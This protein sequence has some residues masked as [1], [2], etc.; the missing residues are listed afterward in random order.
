[1]Q[2]RSALILFLLI[3]TSFLTAES[4]V[5]RVEHP[6]PDLPGRLIQAGMDIAGYAPGEYLDVIGDQEVLQRLRSWGC[7]VDIH[8]TAAQVR[9]SLTTRS[10]RPIDGYREYDDLVDDLTEI[11]NDH[12]DI[13]RMI[14]IGQSWGP[15]YS[16]DG[17][18]AYDDFQHDIWAMKVSDNPDDDEDE[19]CIYYVG[20]HHAREPISVEVT[21][22]ILEHIT[23]NYGTD[24]DVTY[25][26]DNKQIWFV[27]LVNPD[28][29]KIVL[30]QTD[31]WWRK[32]I[33]DNNNNH[34]FDS[35]Y[36]Y[37]TGDD[38]VDPNRNYGYT[39][40][41]VGS[42]DDPNG[43]TY[44]GPNEFSEPETQAV[45]DLVEAHHF[46][47]GISYHSHG[48]LVLYPY[49]YAEGIYAPDHDALSNLGIAM[50]QQIDGLSG[51]HYTPQSSWA[52]Y[53]TMGGTDDWAYGTRGVFAYT[54][55]LAEEFIP[56][57]Y[58][59]QQICDD[60]LPGAL[61]LLRRIDTAT[62]TGHVTEAGTRTPL[63][64]KIIVEEVDSSGEPRMP[65]RANE[66][67]GRYWRMLEPG[68]YTVRYELY[69][70]NT[71]TETVTITS[72]GVTEIDAEL[73]TVGTT[74]IT[75]TVMDAQ[76]QAPV[77]G[78]TV[79][80]LDA[81]IDP[82]TTGNDGT[83]T[84]SDIYLGIYHIRIA[85]DGYGILEQE[86]DLYASTDFVFFL[87]PPFFVD[88]FESGDGNW[89]TT[90]SWGIITDPDAWSGTHAMT[91]SPQGDYNN[92]TETYLTLLDQH[93]FS[94]TSSVG[95]SF[96]A[97][98]EIETDWDYVYFQYRTGSSGWTTVDS[99]TGFED[100]HIRQYHIA[101]AAG[102]TGVRF[103]FM[104]DSDTYVTEDGFYLDDF[105]IYANSG[106][107][108]QYGDID[109]NGTVTVADAVYG[110]E[111]S[112]GLDPIPDIDPI[113]WEP[114]R[115]ASADVDGNQ[116]VQAFDASLISQYASGLIDHFPVTLTGYEAPEA[117][118]DIALDG[119]ELV[120]TATG[121]L[122]GFN[123]ETWSTE[124]VIFGT[125]EVQNDSMTMAGYPGDVVFKLALMSDEAVSGEFLRIGFGVGAGSNYTLPLNMVV[126]DQAVEVELDVSELDAEGGQTPPVET[127]LY[128]NHPNPFN[129]VTAIR[130]SLKNQS[131]T[132]L[133]I[134]NVRGQ[135]IR[136]LTNDT[137]PAGHHQVVWD[138][139]DDRG[140]GVSSGVYLYRLEADG[141]S[142][143]RRMLL[144]K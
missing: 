95:I 56:P 88:D 41:N 86:I 37:G 4:N 23:D 30:D 14:S 40:G 20:A 61:E 114:L 18:S 8:K 140:N 127:R 123:L 112:C 29:H 109:D 19:P 54:V 143:S 72:N 53:P 76:M 10:E 133:A 128:G 94:S 107:P 103:R 96:A 118:I 68:S 59:V 130:F 11:M 17:Y 113:P 136:L 129:P 60:N 108:V 90:G 65:Y 52:L 35:D 117:Q 99:Y 84:I 22:N 34:Q 83:F 132:R 12:L 125:P 36:E 3:L 92:Q 58:Q 1:M 104:F 39:W 74:T 71:Q 28:G 120:F 126:N 16:A 66:L 97:K 142:E 70:Y 32:N 62:L 27:P 85:M 115:L 47:A 80:F 15:Q 102:E 124:T 44:H 119:Q 21:M 135:M 45:R 78:A 57:A 87:H 121:E 82:V 50:A 106:E 51:G 48:Q 33:R 141:K 91:D 131:R 6:D 7:S 25:D 144:L 139:T 24:P 79:E 111:Y 134:Y 31:I 122:Y 67:Y 9:A 38:G 75:G 101:G 13:C 138:G 64:A 5:L 110:L 42:T 116:A 137:L 26:V 100:W 49:G 2:T 63:P 43:S 69:G 73:S 77:A 55:E 89:T 46:V 93:D 105:T 81:P 98:Y